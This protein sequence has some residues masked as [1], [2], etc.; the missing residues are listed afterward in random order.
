MNQVLIDR[1]KILKYLASDEFS[2]KYIAIDLHSPS[3][4]KVIVKSFILK[5]TKNSEAIAKSLQ[6]HICQ[7]EKLGFSS[8]HIPNIYGYFEY[9]QK[10]YLIE[11]Y[12]EGQNLTQLGMISSEQ[13]ITILSSLLETLG[14]FHQQHLIHGQIKPEN[15]IIRKENNL[16]VLTGYVASK[17]ILGGKTKTINSPALYST[18]IYNLSLAM[19]CALTGTS[20]KELAIDQ[21]T[22]ELYWESLGANLSPKLKQVLQKG[23]H[24]QV[25]QRY[26]NVKAM[27]LDLE[28][29]PATIQHQ[30][31][32]APPRN[33]FILMLV[34]LILFALNITSAF[35]FTKKAQDVQAQLDKLYLY[36]ATEEDQFKDE[37]QT[38]E[39]SIN[40]QQQQYSE[41]EE[42][43]V[44]QEELLQEK[45]QQLKLQQNAIAKKNKLIEA[46]EDTIQNQ[47][48][49]IKKLQSV[50][51]GYL[52]KRTSY[53]QD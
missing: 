49:E 22:Q 25:S 40:E 3:Q 20:I 51:D 5:D 50:L 35:L 13:C 11:E 33:N 44:K 29:K 2:D 1:F 48:R 24:P 4:K 46:Q 14:H 23:I 26:D 9:Q 32:T 6:K 45:D 53:S 52:H 21:I 39:T 37:I 30:V 27:S 16:P 12:I 43:R 38:L 36:V 7:L 10:Y 17:T 41:I 31:V 15:I 8:L 18:D 19:I 34:A 47:N 42:A 28:D